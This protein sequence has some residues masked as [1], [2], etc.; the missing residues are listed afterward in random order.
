MASIIRGDDDFDTAST[1]KASQIGWG[2]TIQSPSRALGTTYTNST[3]RPIFVEVRLYHTG[4]TQFEC[5]VDGITTQLSSNNS[6]WWCSVSF[7][8]PNGSTYLIPTPTYS[9]FGWTELR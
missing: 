3:G 7:V 8:V 4:A 5:K 9:S 1:T 6:G 2:Q